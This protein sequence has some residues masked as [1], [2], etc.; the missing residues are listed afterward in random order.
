MHFIVSVLVQNNIL[1][2]IKTPGFLFKRYIRI[3][4]R[5]FECFQTTVFFKVEKK[6]LFNKKKEEKLARINIGIFRI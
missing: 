6:N 1:K 4:L 2:K 3:F 5:F